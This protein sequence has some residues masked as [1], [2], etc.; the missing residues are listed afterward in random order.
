M[1]SKWVK[2]NDYKLY[3]ITLKN[4]KIIK[5]WSVGKEL[6]KV[7][8]DYDVPYMVYK[9]NKKK[10]EEKELKKDNENMEQNE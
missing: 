10:V 4:G 7:L 2:F 1:K 5:F 8:K 3:D 6:E 9:D